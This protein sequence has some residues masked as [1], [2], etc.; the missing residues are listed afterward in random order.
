MA[1]F[2]TNNLPLLIHIRDVGQEIDKTFHTR[3][4]ENYIE[5]VNSHCI[6]LVTHAQKQAQNAIRRPDL[7]KPTVLL[8]TDQCEKAQKSHEAHRDRSQLA[9][10]SFCW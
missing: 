7:S 6:T 2:I 5:D 1:P 9:S 10:N 4:H 3:Q 8:N